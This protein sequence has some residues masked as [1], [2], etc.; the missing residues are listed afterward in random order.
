MYHVKIYTLRLIECISQKIYGV[1]WSNI[2]K[3]TNIFGLKI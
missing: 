1:G 3:H 2:K